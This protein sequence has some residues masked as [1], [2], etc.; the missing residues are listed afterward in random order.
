LFNSLL[1]LLGHGRIDPLAAVSSLCYADC[2][3]SAALNID[4]FICFQTL[5]ALGGTTAD[6]D[7]S[8]DLTIDD[9][10]CFQ[11]AFAL[12]C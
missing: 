10:V 1:G 11:T 2:D 3:G 7:E 5:F 12:G 8:G 9:F 6:C 4:D